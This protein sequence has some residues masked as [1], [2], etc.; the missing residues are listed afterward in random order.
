LSPPSTLHVECI[1]NDMH[2]LT[3]MLE[4]YVDYM[5]VWIIIVDIT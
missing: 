2:V 1:G 3:I 5:G 4:S